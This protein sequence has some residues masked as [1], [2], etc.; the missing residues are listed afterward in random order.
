MFQGG[1]SS[2]NG[3]GSGGGS[4]S[5][6]SATT[7]AAGG[8]TGTIDYPTETGTPNDHSIN[9]GTPEPAG[10][11]TTTD[12]GTGGSSTGGTGG[13]GNG[14]G[15]N[16]PSSQDVEVVDHL[17]TRRVDL[18]IGLQGDPKLRE[19]V[20]PMTILPD[21]RPPV[22]AYL[23]TDEKGKRAAFVIAK[24]ATMAG[25]PPPACPRLKTASTSPCRRARPRRSTSAQTDRRTNYA[26]FRYGMSNTRLT[27]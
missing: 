27:K 8:G 6:T 10:D 19:N 15:D 7:A 23:G 9:A 18:M 14:H 2:S 17:V 20:K 5:P 12:T 3:D 1:E 21:A 22:V 13:N 26:C 4:S 25:G 24:G 16:Q 11:D